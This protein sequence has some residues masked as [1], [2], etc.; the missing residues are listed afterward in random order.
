MQGT[1]SPTYNFIGE[2][3][4]DTDGSSFIANANGGKT[5]ISDDFD[6]NLEEAKQLLADAGYS[7]G[8][9]LPT[10]EFILKKKENNNDKRAS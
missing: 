1:Y 10:I 6:A 8:A 3:W 2:G 4:I 5:Y 7:D 9:G